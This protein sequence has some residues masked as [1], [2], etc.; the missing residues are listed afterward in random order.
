MIL[1]SITAQGLLPAQA[2]ALRQRGYLL[3]KVDADAADRLCASLPVTAILTYNDRGLRA[4]YPGRRILTLSAD[5]DAALANISAPPPTRRTSLYLPSDRAEAMVLVD[6]LDFTPAEYTLLRVLAE[7]NSP[8]PALDLAVFLGRR[9]PGDDVDS[10]KYHRARIR[11]KTAA[12]G[13]PDLISYIHPD[14]FSLAF[15]YCIRLP[16]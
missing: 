10:V 2:K 14:G 4:R 12:A 6:H 5:L 7:A 13:L 3:A 15:P 11:K 8:I 16:E 9:C 1:L